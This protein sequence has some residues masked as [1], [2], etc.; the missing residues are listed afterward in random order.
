MI[1]IHISPQDLERLKQERYTHPHPRFQR[2]LEALYL[3]GMGYLRH[4]VARI[5]GV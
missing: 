3:V 2:K 4:D 1:S 5:V